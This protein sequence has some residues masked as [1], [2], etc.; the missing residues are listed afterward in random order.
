[1]VNT[2]SSSSIERLVIAPRIRKAAKFHCNRN[3]R[4][5]V[6][7]PSWWLACARCACVF[8]T[9]LMEQTD[10]GLAAAAATREAARRRREAESTAARQSKT[11]E[12]PRKRAHTE[13]ERPPCTHEVE[14]PDG[15]EEASRNLDSAVHGEKRG[16]VGC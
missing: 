11:E 9:Q 1:M 16:D 12:P 5:R 6:K 7:L 4:T 8:G 3:L 10:E 13:G 14:V 2:I 15:F